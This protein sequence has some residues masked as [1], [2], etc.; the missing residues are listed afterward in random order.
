[1]TKQLTIETAETLLNNANEAL[2]NYKKDLF[3]QR[4]REFYDAGG[5]KTCHGQGTV[6]TWGTMDSIHG[7]YDEFG[8]CP[9][10]NGEQM[11]WVGVN[12][13]RKRNHPKVSASAIPPL[14]ATD[15]E[16]SKLDYLV[17]EVSKA[18]DTL[19]KV[20]EQYK[21]IK[22]SRVRVVR[23]R[24]TP[25]GTEG[26]VFWIGEGTSGRGYY[27]E[28]VTRVGIKTDDGVTYWVN[29]INYCVNLTPRTDADIDADNK[30][31]KRASIARNLTHKGS[32]IVS[33]RVSGTVAWA[34]YTKRGNGPW[35][36]LV[37]SGGDFWLDASEIS[38]VDGQSIQA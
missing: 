6:C 22:G 21:I 8:P 30:A 13:I 32:Q 5:C 12:R 10:C 33:K 9:D 14:A 28:T 38:A 20:K 16:K 31:Q 23:G 25:Q 18:E 4:E 29:N 36:A 17:N 15:A 3:T 34:G 26:V 37:K 1:M 35:R 27:A 2:R 19:K 24:K 7:C 11:P